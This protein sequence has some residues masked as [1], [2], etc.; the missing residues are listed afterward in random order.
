[1]GTGR[2]RNRGLHRCAGGGVGKRGVQTAKN[3]MKKY[4]QTIAR[5]QKNAAKG[6]RGTRGE[7]KEKKKE[8]GHGSIM[9]EYRKTQGSGGLSCEIVRQGE[10]TSCGKKK[11]EPVALSRSE[12]CNVQTHGHT[13]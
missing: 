2:Q 12:T 7:K 10:F 11:N 5:E 8:K 9:G 3:K 6:T 4:Y 13:M 1:M